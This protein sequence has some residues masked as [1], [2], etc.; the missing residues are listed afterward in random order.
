MLQVENL[1]QQKSDSSWTSDAGHPNLVSN[2]K[3][4]HYT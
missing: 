1:I 2:G 3:V 4:S